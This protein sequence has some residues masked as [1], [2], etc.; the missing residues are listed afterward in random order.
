MNPYMNQQ[1]IYILLMITPT[2][3][4]WIL[5]TRAHDVHTSDV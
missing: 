4:M 3:Q 5:S 2:S 1:K